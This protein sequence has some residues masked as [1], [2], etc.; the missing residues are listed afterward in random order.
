MS[1]QPDVIE[2]C[3]TQNGWIILPAVGGAMGYKSLS[4]AVVARSPEE[5]ARLVAEWA[6][7]A[8]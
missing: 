7:T 5:L 1:D 2:I 4:V 8:K 3:R 6:G